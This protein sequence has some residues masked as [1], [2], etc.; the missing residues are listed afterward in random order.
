ME[1]VVY[2]IPLICE[3]E[4]QWAKWLIAQANNNN[5]HAGNFNARNVC[6]K[7]CNS[8]LIIP[9]NMESLKIDIIEKIVLDG[10]SQT[11]ENSST[12]DK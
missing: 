2:V 4:F 12:P 6:D 9:G 1:K 3:D 11:L 10:H 5:L 8:E 7:V